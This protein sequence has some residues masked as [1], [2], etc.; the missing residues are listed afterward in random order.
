MSLDASLVAEAVR[1]AVA[2]LV[3]E[4]AAMRAAL[5]PALL[6][7]A[8]VEERYGIPRSSQRRYVREGRLKKVT[9]GR[10]VLIDVSRLQ[11]SS[12]DE[13]AAMAVEARR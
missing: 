8:E 13:I 9:I 4:I 1:A 10:T 6:R 5:P 12:D 7:P 11:P 3:A 2:P